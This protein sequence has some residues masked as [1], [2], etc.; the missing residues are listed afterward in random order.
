MRRSF[1]LA[2]LMLLSAISF[3]C[4]RQEAPVQEKKTIIVIHNL[5]HQSVSFYQFMSAIEEAFPDTSLYHIDYA[6]VTEAYYPWPNE[7]FSELLMSKLDIIEKKIDTDLLILYSDQ[8]LH[9]A[10]R[11]HHKILDSIPVVF[12]GATWPEHEGLLKERK[13]FT[14]YRMPLGI[15]QTLD[16]MRDMGCKP[17]V[18]TNMDSTYLDTYVREEIFTQLSEDTVHYAA[19]LDYS[20]ADHFIPEEERDKTKTTLIPIQLRCRSA[21]GFDAIKMLNCAESGCSYLKIKDDKAGINS[22]SWPVGL[23]Y[24][25]TPE[26]FNLSYHSAVNACAGGYMVPFGVMMPELKTMVDEILFEGK[27]PEDIA[28]RTLQPEWWLDWKVLKTSH[29]FGNELPRYAHV[30]NLPWRERNLV[31][32]IISE[33]WIGIVAL[34]FFLILILLMLYFFISNQARSKALIKEGQEA[35][36]MMFHIE[37]AL[38]AANCHFFRVRRS[39]SIH[40]NETF[41]DICGDRQVPTRLEDFVGMISSDKR[42][43]FMDIIDGGSGDGSVR[44]LNFE[45]LGHHFTARIVTNTD[46][47]MSDLAYGVLFNMDTNYQIEQ[48]KNEAFKIEEQSTMKRAFL[49]SMGHEIRTPLN[50]IL[51]YSRLLFDM[52]GELDQEEMK[53]YSGV[54]RQNSEQLLSLIDDVLSYSSKEGR[55]PDIVLSK[56]RVSDLMDEIYMTYR[57]IVPAHLKFKLKKGGEDDF[58]MVNRGSMLQVLS[59]LMNNAVKFT[60][61][62]SITLGWKDEGD[63]VL[64]Y[65][66]DTGCGIPQENLS[67]IFDKYAKVRA[68]TEG[69]GLGLSLCNKLVSKMNGKIEV[70]STLGMGSCFQVRF[71]RIDN[72]L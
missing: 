61:E 69:A 22:L 42:E 38:A 43:E 27:A 33:Y 37:E 5:S 48:Q 59:N 47:L 8:V 46:N 16:M 31:N 4:L 41:R 53:S 34:M 1:L 29:A 49:A 12:A 26:R 24:S 13:N 17:W 54:I 19:N 68:S 39:G 23:F 62:G 20:S 21:S 3:S 58:I 57:V 72:T 51:G 70:S 35:E 64:I 65:V 44:N 36:R 71:K 32:S 11:C 56:K 52:Y 40:F 63:D 18:I 55:E 60:A 67:T 25:V 15:K 10:A 45:L 14:G 66:Q 2:A 7:D 28:W 6:A 9:A 30:V 50:A